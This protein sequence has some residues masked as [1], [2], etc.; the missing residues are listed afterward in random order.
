MKMQDLNPLSDEQ[1]ADSLKDV[2]KRLF[3]LRF[4]AATEKLEKPT[5]LAALRKDIARIKTLQ[6]RRELDKTTSTT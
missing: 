5:E 3:R 1:L 2:G 4:Q 6:R